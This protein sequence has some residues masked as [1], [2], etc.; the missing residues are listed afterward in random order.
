MKATKV[1]VGDDQSA[2]GAGLADVVKKTLG[3]S[4]V[5]TDKTE[6]DGKQTDFS[7]FV[8]KVVASK[9]TVLFYGGYYQ[10]AGLIRK[11]LT[12]SGWKGILVGGDGMKDAGL[13]KAA[14]NAVAV[15]TIVTCPCSPPEKSGGTFVTDYKAK[16]NVAA[17]TYSDVAFDAANLLLGGLDGGNTTPAKMN[18]YLK[19]ADFKGIANEYKFTDKGELDPSLLKV[20]TFKFDATGNQI[21]D[22]EVKTS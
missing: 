20:W 4:V 8:Q 14:G 13:A 22:Q 16:W 6:A 21:A 2:Y 9:A 10:N 15:G 17:G 12:A 3:A 11:Q 5:G 7:G 19:T 1:F 18:D